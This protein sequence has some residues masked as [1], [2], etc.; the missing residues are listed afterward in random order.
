MRDDDMIDVISRLLR[1]DI[2]MR[3]MASHAVISF[4]RRE[5]TFSAL[6]RD[7]FIYDIL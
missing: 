6:R 4:E 2:A 5:A 7:A 1:C 3:D